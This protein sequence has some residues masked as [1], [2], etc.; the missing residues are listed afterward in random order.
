MS[1]PKCVVPSDE[2]YMSSEDLRVHSIGVVERIG[3]IEA[4]KHFF[5]TPKDLLSTPYKSAYFGFGCGPPTKWYRYQD[6]RNVAIEKHGLETLRKKW[7]ARKKRQVNQEKKMAKA[8]QAEEELAKTKPSTPVVDS[9]EIQ[10]LR[11]SLLKMAKKKLHFEM[12]GAPGK[13]RVE[14]PMVQQSTFAT[15]IGKPNDPELHSLVKGGVYYSEDVIAAD[16]FGSET[17]LSKFFSREGVGQRIGDHVVMKYK[18]STSEMSIS[19]YA[20]IERGW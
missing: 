6:V 3:S 18:P 19:G 11:K 17:D 13:W 1:S 4:I 8:K 16:L 15:L 5:L 20:E 7:N 12:S 2:D 9:K 14:V 10:K